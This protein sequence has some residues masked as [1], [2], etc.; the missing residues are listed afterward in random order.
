MSRVRREFADQ[1]SVG[2]TL[3]SANRG[4]IDSL[5]FLP[6]SAVTT[7]ADYDW[8]L[9]SAGSH[10]HLGR[11]AR[12]GQRGRDRRVAAQ[13]RPQL[14]APDADH[15][16]FYPSADSMRATL[17]R[18][19][20]QDCRRKV[21]GNV[22]VAYKTPGFEVNEVGF[23]RRADEIKQRASSDIKAMFLSFIGSVAYY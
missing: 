6:D 18:W 1:S 2:L 11:F 17:A 23:L 12:G 14:P 9:G 20:S 22:M 16:E 3:T 4:R 10:R 13:Q 7:G 8:R 19:R 5:S 15:V 21:R